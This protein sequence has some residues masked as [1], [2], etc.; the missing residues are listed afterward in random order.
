MSAT[1]SPVQL[2]TFGFGAYTIFY[3]LYNMPMNGYHFVLVIHFQFFSLHISLFPRLH[4]LV[5]KTNC[6]AM[7]K[8]TIRMRARNETKEGQLKNEAKISVNMVLLYIVHICIWYKYYIF[9]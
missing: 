5:I 8:L 7:H 4:E 1:I 2:A 3:I 6:A 9:V